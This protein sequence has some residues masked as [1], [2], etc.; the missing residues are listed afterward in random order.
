MAFTTFKILVD[1]VRKGEKFQIRISSGS[2]PNGIAYG[3]LTFVQVIFNP[4][5]MM[6]DTCLFAHGFS[7]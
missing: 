7:F 4:L 3:V 1:S 6:A 2:S 5:S